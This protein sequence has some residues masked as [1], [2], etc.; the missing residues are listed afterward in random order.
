MIDVDRDEI[1]RIARSRGV[2]RLRVFGSALTS[3]FD[4]ASSDVD[5]LVDLATS[6]ADDFD[7]Y[8]GLKEDLERAFGRPV[9]LVMIEA[10][11]NPFF[12]ERMLSTA[13]ELYA[14]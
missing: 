12:R 1:A 10:V 4:P 5:V 2:S 6:G 14:A 3:S 7:A 8:F 9:D 11:R 13:E